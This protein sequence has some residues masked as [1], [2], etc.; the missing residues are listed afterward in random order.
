MIK[1]CAYYVDNL[2]YGYQVYC[3]NPT[4]YWINPLG[5]VLI[6]VWVGCFIYFYFTQNNKMQ[7]L[8]VKK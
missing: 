5:W 4:E 1:G 8:L 2:V 6:A 3:A 7:D